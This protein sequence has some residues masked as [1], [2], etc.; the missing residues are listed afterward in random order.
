[1]E[2]SFGEGAIR[3]NY[4]RFNSSQRKELEVVIE[5][6]TRYIQTS[7]RMLSDIPYWWAHNKPTC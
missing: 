2:F 5:V 3:S 1:M 7:Y 6:S 4:R